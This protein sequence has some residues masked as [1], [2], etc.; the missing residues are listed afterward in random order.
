MPWLDLTCRRKT[1]CFL[2]LETL[3]MNPVSN[4]YDMQPL[5][6]PSLDFICLYSFLINLRKTT[7]LSSPLWWL[8]SCPL[9]GITSINWCQF[10][11]AA[12]PRTETFSILPNLDT[13]TFVPKFQNDVFLMSKNKA[14]YNISLSKLSRNREDFPWSLFIPGRVKNI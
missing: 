13:H 3:L 10:Q 7:L 2:T 5:S 6:E 4:L 1:F 12:V 14:F 9:S 8:F 11:T